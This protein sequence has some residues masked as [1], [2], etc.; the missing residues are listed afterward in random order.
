MNHKPN[1]LP[2]QDYALDEVTNPMDGYLAN[3]IDA[4]EAWSG[5]PTEP[6][7][8]ALAA[9][10]MTGCA[11]LHTTM[12]RIEAAHAQ[13]SWIRDGLESVA[14]AIDRHAASVD[15]QTQALSVLASAM[16]DDLPGALAVHSDEVA[17]G[18]E[19]VAASVDALR[20]ARTNT[21]YPQPG[22]EA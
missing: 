8:A 17:S 2:C 20:S 10:Y 7:G 12:W 9:A 3:A 22:D 1:G 15:R 14:A 6:S 13:A 16:A 19:S 21:N 4:V 18:L 11:E 5:N